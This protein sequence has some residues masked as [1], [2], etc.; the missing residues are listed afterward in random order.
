[1]SFLSFYE[2][3]RLEFNCSWMEYLKFQYCWNCPIIVTPIPVISPLPCVSSVSKLTFLHCQ[4]N[5][6]VALLKILFSNQ[7]KKNLSIHSTS[8]SKTLTFKIKNKHHLSTTTLKLLFHG[9]VPRVLVNCFTAIPTLNR[10]PYIFYILK[11]YIITE[12]IHYYYYYYYYY[13]IKI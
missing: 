1:M 10:R 9:S 6:R 12:N 3:L 7:I 4:L 5:R 8:F 11:F 2:N 13:Y